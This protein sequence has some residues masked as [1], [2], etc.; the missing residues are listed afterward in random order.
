MT[1]PATPV[2]FSVS[3][4]LPTLAVVCL[5][6]ADRFS[7]VFCTC[8]LKW[9]LVALIACSFYVLIGNL[10]VFITEMAIK[11]LFS[12]FWLPS[13]KKLFIYFGYEVFPLRLFYF[14]F[15]CMCMLTTYLFVHFM[16]MVPAEPKRCQSLEMDYRQL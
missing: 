4:N 7:E 3:P 15:M 5:V 6:N 10:C 11:L 13:Y 2:R 16:Y 8:G 9:C 14:Y 1:L 12:S